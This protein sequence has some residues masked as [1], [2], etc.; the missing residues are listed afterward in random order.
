MNYSLSSVVVWTMA[1]SLSSKCIVQAQLSSS[2]P[3]SGSPNSGDMALWMVSLSKE[4]AAPVTMEFSGCGSVR[5]SSAGHRE[6]R[7]MV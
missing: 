5:T 7:R 6:S 2:N 4:V 3:S 1:S